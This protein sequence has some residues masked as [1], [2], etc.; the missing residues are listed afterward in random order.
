MYFK[1]EKP[2]QCPTC[3]QKFAQ[4]YNM[5]SHLKVHQGITRTNKVQKCTLCNKSFARKAKLDQHMEDCHP[6]M[7]ILIP[8]PRVKNEFQVTELNNLPVLLN[9]DPINQPQNN[10]NYFITEIEESEHTLLKVEYVN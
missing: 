8:A 5:N 7:P 3:G 6:K 10:E 2:F 1:G 9:V 4:R